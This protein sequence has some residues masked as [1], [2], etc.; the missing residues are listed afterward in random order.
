MFVHITYKVINIALFFTLF[1]FSG[2]TTG[3]INK[4]HEYQKGEIILTVEGIKKHEGDIIVALFIN[5]H[6]FLK[7]D[8]KS[9]YFPV[10]GLATMEIKLDDIPY[11]KY[12][13]SIIHDKNSNKK[14]D[15]NFLG[16]P[17]ESYGF[18]NNPFSK[19]GPPSFEKASFVINEPL[20][21]MKIGL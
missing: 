21:Y 11:G 6:S 16:I 8:F 4:S 3:N 1:L 19:F 5:K 13:I 17:S 18:S 12:A 15:T 14:L 10:N 9:W 20:V 7:E 2:A